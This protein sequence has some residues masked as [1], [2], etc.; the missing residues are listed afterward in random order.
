[1]V[2]TFTLARPVPLIKADL[3][4]VFTALKQ[5]RLPALGMVRPVVRLTL[6]TAG[7]VTGV[8]IEVPPQPLERIQRLVVI[9]CDKTRAD[10]VFRETRLLPGAP[11]DTDQLT[12][13]QA[14]LSYLGA[15]Q[16]VDLKSM[17]ME[18]EAA[19]PAAAA[20]Q[21]EP[22]ENAPSAIPAEPQTA[23]GPGGDRPAAGDAGP[24]S[25]WKAGDLQ[26]NVEERPPYVITTSFG[27]DKSQGYH[28]G[29][30]LQQLNV[31]G[32]GR[33][34]DYGIRAGNGTIHNPTLARL[35]P[36][37]AYNRSV[38]SF[39][40]GY[41]DPWFA[42]GA[43]KNLLADHTQFRSEGAYIQELQDLYALHRRRFTNSL[44]WNVA[45]HVS[46]QLGY[47]WERVD[48]ASALAGIGTDQLAIIARYP[49]QTVVSAPFAQV[50]RDTRDN[51]LDPTSGMYSVARVEF[52]NQLFRTSSNSSFVKVDLRNQWTWPLG[53]KAQAGVVALGLRVGVAKP[54][55]HSAEDLPLSERFFAGGPFTFRGVEP[56]ALGA[57][58][59]IP[60]YSPTGQPVLDAFGNQVYYATPVGGQGLALINLEYRFPILRRTVWGEVFMDS[61]QVYQS[62]TRLS[63]A[64][65]SQQVANEAPEAAFPP[66]RTALGVG[67]IFKIGIPLK[68]EYAADINRILGRSRS[69]ADRDTQLKSLL[70]SAGFQ[71]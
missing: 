6:E 67:L 1:M 16:R 7:E 48:V 11:L 27:Y 15:F 46:F 35:F 56:D 44:Q 23:A 47:R 10:A 5:Q 52:A 13:A 70:V 40:V 57:Q 42:P 61:G 65:R 53:R 63:E 21:G 34:I 39:T 68:V 49:T 62:L 22:T 2:L 26:L 4:R 66:F 9:G 50:A 71:F 58:A 33:T 38:D 64:E 29:L 17:G 28:V 31:G 3:T 55:A 30:G 14:R 19:A 37:G 32:M 24:P 20:V 12:R 45:S 36:T 43:L 18:A 51:V 8:R 54:T 69:Q 25:P 60:L 59:L 41:T